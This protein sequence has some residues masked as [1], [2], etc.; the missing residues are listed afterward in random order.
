M[1]KIII[2]PW[3]IGS[4]QTQH[5]ALHQMDLKHETVVLN[6]KGERVP[7]S[8]C[9]E[10]VVHGGTTHEASRRQNGR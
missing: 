7:T 6:I 4:Q 1:N 3:F 10:P 2:I 8:Y 5:I 9:Y